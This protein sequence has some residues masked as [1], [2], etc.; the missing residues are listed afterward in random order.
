MTERN[1]WIEVLCDDGEQ[2][3]CAVPFSPS[4]AWGAREAISEAEFY[5]QKPVEISQ[6]VDNDT[7]EVLYD[8]DAGIGAYR[9]E[10][11]ADWCGGFN[12]P[13][14]NGMVKHT[15]TGHVGHPTTEERP[16]RELGTNS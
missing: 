1:L 13:T 11:D 6:I 4:L 14:V 10:Y 8:K 2:F 9:A 3:G 7:D 12:R 5:G 15:G 16:L